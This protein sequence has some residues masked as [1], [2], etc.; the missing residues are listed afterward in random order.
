MREPEAL[1]HRVSLALE[2]A[3]LSEHLRV[4]LLGRAPKMVIHAV[5]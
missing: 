3:S 4:P 2:L 5:D 1:R